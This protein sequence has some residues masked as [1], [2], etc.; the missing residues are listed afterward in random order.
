MVRTRHYACSHV[1][2]F[3]ICSIP[4]IHKKETDGSI[5]GLNELHIKAMSNNVLP[6]SKTFFVNA[7]FA[8]LTL[9]SM[10]LAAIASLKMR[11]KTTS[12]DF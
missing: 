10:S 7:N 9:F 8:L 3:A 11:R 6:S 12:S 5:R 4:L 1:L 2:R